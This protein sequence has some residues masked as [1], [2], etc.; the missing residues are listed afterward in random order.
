MRGPFKNICFFI[1]VLFSSVCFAEERDWSFIQAV[2]GLA[3]GEPYRE[4]GRLILPLHCD[5]SG[6]A[7]ITVKPTLLNSALAFESVH[8]ERHGTSIFLKVSTTI[9]TQKHP[10]A[11]CENVELGELPGGRYSVFYGEAPS[12]FN[13]HEQVV[14]LGEIEIRL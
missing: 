10:K 4:N 6:L 12:S 13:S 3:I 2:G 11:T 7:E 8:L 9:A 14:K 1:L 5:V